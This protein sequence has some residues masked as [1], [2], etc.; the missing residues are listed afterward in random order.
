[1]EQQDK[2]SGPQKNGIFGLPYYFC[3]PWVWVWGLKFILKIYWVKGSVPVLF[4]N[5][6][7]KGERG[8]KERDWKFLN[9]AHRTFDIIN[10]SPPV[11][12]A[13]HT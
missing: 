13:Q 6:L 12:A 5:L 11:Q 7:H 9:K 8:R 1:M 3:I 2:K 10:T 4:R